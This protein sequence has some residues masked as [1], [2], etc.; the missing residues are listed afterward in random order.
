MTALYEWM[1]AGADEGRIAPLRY[2]EGEAAAPETAFEGEYAFV[3]I[4]Y[5]L[6]D[7]ETSTLLTQSVSTADAFESAASAPRDARFAAAVAAFGD[8]LRG[9]R[10][11]GDYGYGD[12]IALAQSARGGGPARLPQRVRPPGAPGRVDCDPG[13]LSGFSRSDVTKSVLVGHT[14]RLRCSAGRGRKSRVPHAG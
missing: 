6:P 2:R 7:A 5:K 3:K 9:G 14:D 1:P 4:R 12:V 10:Y 11:S 8:L 13:A